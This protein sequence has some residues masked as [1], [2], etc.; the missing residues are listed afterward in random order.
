MD[1]IKCK[2]LMIS[3]IK[4]K[5]KWWFRDL[6]KPLG[7]KPNL[8][9][10]KGQVQTICFHGICGDD[11]NYINGRFLKE[12]QFREIIEE[13][14]KL[15]NVISLNDFRTNNLDTNR[16]NVFI[17]FDDGYKNNLNLGL[18]ILEEN[19][20]VA[21]IFVNGKRNKFQLIDLLDISRNAKVSLEPLKSGL[22]DLSNFSFQEIKKW[23]CHCNLSNYQTAYDIL[24]DMVEP[25]I[26]DYL[27]YCELMSK[28]E[29]K[30]VAQSKTLSIAN[31]GFNH[32]S[33]L[34]LSES[35]IENEFSEI[36]TYLSSL[37][38]DNWDIFAY[39]Y[40]YYSEEI[41]RK[42]KGLGVKHQFSI[43]GKGF[44]KFEVED[45]LVVNPY[46][47]VYN[48]IKAIADGHY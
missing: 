3:K 28:D 45:R 26:E 8:H 38:S 9:W 31:H 7:L 4:L 32:V 6:I 35:G 19:N 44:S 21:T 10:R 33:F 25:L 20:C 46:I 47:S 42:L 22:K 37:G 30:S 39:P 34:S 2:D 41:S 14:S 29:L 16:L 12:T 13:A 5:L 43:D 40:S 18:P 27:V 48:Q 23:L 15:F 1:S 36:K 17:T 24:F 11:D